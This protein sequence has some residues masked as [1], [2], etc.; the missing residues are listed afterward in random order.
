[1]VAYVPVAVTED[2]RAV[3]AAGHQMLDF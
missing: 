2:R 1:L 3:L